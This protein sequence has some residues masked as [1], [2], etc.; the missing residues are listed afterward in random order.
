MSKLDKWSDEDF[1]L[2][3]KDS[4]SIAE[5]SR[6]LGYTSKGGGVSNMVKDRIA[7]LNIN[8]EHFSKY[9]KVSSN[10][11]KYDSISDILIENSTYTNNTSLKKKL[12]NEGLLIY[13]CKICRLTSWLEKPI[14]LQ[15]DHVNGINS[16][17][18]L[19]NLRLLCP[20]C[21]SQTETFSG[22]NASHD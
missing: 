17:N 6:K 13:E 15:L 8:V 9:S 2:L 5:I 14:S 21:H 18:R 4:V 7:K 19:E 3:V 20:N 22:K 11:V 10:R 1:I 16:D 12:V